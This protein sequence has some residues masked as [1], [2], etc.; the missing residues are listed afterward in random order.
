MTGPDVPLLRVDGVSVRLAS[1]R[2]HRRGARLAVSDVSLDVHAAEIVGIVGESGAG[3][4]TL[5][6]AIARRHPVLSGRI[7]FAGRD[8]TDVRGSDLKELRRKIQMVFQDPYGSL[9][10]RIRVADI[11]TEPL[12]V[13]G[14]LSGRRADRAERTR[15]AETL[16]EECG[17]PAGCGDEMADAFS[18]GQRQRISIA[19]ALAV[20]PRLLVADE[21]TSA[22]DVSVQAQILQLLQRLQAAHGMAIVLVS[23]NLA[24]VRQV[25][26]R[27]VVMYAGR[28][29]ESGTTAS[30]FSQPSHPYTRELLAS[31]PSLDPAAERLRRAARSS[32]EQASD[33]GISAA[34]CPH[35][36]RCPIAEEQCTTVPPAHREMDPGHWVACHRAEEPNDNR[37][38]RNEAIDSVR[39]GRP[40]VRGG[41]GLR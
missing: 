37:G 18:G 19:R 24:V 4:S 25:A 2:D 27:V 7:H 16:L 34:G 39:A 26:S 36:A 10:P 12:V 3:K 38:R 41:H 1:A 15:R 28:V 9:P 17:L 32:V 33:A 30:V 35:A 31:V 13:H 29:V 21:P 40:A 6:F 23:H 22:L 20:Q 14:Q 5:G 11:V 8:V